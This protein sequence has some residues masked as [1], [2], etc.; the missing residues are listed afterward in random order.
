MSADLITANLFLHHFEPERLSVLLD[1]IA[2]AT[3]AFVACEPERGLSGLIGSRLLWAIGCNDVSRH[4]AIT[5]VRAGFRDAELS[6][7]WPKG[8]WALAENAAFP[9]SHCFVARR[10]GA[11]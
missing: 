1:G 3:E 8:R 9:F 11:S 4:D 6:A 5:S 2:R 10:D 7:L